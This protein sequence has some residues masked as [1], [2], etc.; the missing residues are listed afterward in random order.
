MLVSLFSDPVL[1]ELSGGGDV[2]TYWQYNFTYF[3]LR[4]PMND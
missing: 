3:M 2:V 1:S 4:R